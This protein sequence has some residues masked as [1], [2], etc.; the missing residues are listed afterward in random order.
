MPKLLIPSYFFPF[1]R[2]R[3]R[4]KLINNLEGERLILSHSNTEIRAEFPRKC[5]R[6]EKFKK[7]LIDEARQGRK[8]DDSTLEEV[9]I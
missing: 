3:E 6:K 8:R 5:L 1:F 7:F 4:M 2:Y 9:L